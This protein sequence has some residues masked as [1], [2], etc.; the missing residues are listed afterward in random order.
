MKVLFLIFSPG[1]GHARCA[2]AISAALESRRDDVECDYLDLHDLTD[3]RASAAVKD[4]YL[5][6]TS[7]QPELYQRLYDLDR[8]LYRQLAGEAPADSEVAGFLAEQQRRSFPEFARRPWFANR[9]PNLDTALLNT[10]INGVREH[11]RFPASRL[12]LKGVLQ[13]IGRGLTSRLKEAVQARKPDVLV[14]TH[15]YPASLLSRV[16]ATGALKQ[17]LIGVVTDFGVHGIWVRSTPRRYCVGHEFTAQ[18]L[19][20]GGVHPEQVQVTGIPLMPAFAD[21][22]GQQ[23]ARRRLGLDDR[24]TALVT[25]G[26]YGI[27]VVEAVES[28]ASAGLDTMRVLVTSG[29]RVAGHDRVSAL[30]AAHPERV[31]IYSWSKDMALLMRAADVVVGKPG[32]LTV[33]ESLA[34]GRPFIAI[35]SLGGGEAHNLRFLEH[36][37]VGERVSVVDLPQRLRAL[38]ADRAALAAW[39]RRARTAGRRRGA[40]TVAALVEQCARR[41]ALQEAAGQA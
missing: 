4:G 8:G 9:Y 41:P 18:M 19:I 32:G 33:S 10:L 38:F 7:E 25:G 35:R 23:Q 11:W 22:P 14:A 3:P 40:R 15:M 27:G 21:P 31:R 28:I 24:P 39:Q 2:E 29:E 16:I 34:C 13:L 6:M 26:E 1:K 30:A 37:G 20:E 17:P 5:R 36:H 12:L